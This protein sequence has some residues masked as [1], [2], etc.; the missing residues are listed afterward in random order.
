MGYS[1]DDSGDSVL[2]K[3]YIA[4]VIITFL[5]LGIA[6]ASKEVSHIDTGY[7]EHYQEETKNVLNPTFINY[8]IILTAGLMTFRLL[9]NHRGFMLNAGVLVLLAVTV[10]FMAF[11][12]CRA[13]G[14]A[15]MITGVLT[16]LNVLVSYRLNKATI[17][18]AV[19]LVIIAILFLYQGF[20]YA[21]ITEVP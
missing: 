15:L 9:L 4:I 1:K 6:Y 10:L 17:Y 3:V 11:A 2:Y 5:V 7:L 16:G 12:S 18:E 20:T 13:F 8:L 14:V 19:L 21:R